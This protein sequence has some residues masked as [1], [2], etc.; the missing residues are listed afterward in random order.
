MKMKGMRAG[1]FGASLTHEGVA[2]VV[3]LGA[4]CGTWHRVW[5]MIQSARK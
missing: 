2:K 3:P 4:V 5:S 1:H